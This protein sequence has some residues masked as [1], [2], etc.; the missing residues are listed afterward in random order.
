MHTA[1]FWESMWPHKAVPGW[2]VKGMRIPIERKGMKGR[3]LVY[4]CGHCYPGKAGRE[5]DSDCTRTRR[6]G[7][8]EEI[9]CHKKSWACPFDTVGPAGNLIRISG[10]LGII[11]FSV[12]SPC[13][14]LNKPLSFYFLRLKEYWHDLFP[15]LNLVSFSSI[16]QIFIE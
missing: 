6:H 3:V 12:P 10:Y 14:A 13:S 7:T 11:I 4:A 1:V 8:L 5:H 15:Q 2:R 16:Q 9:T